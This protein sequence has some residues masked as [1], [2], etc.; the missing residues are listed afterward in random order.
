MKI[1]PIKK[2]DNDKLI[3]AASKLASV[4][5]LAVTE[6]NLVYLNIDD[7]YIHQLFPLLEGKKIEKPDYFG[8][9]LIGAHVSTIYPEENKLI[10]NEDLGEKHRFKVKGAYTAKLDTKKY[11]VITVDSPSLVQLRKKYELPQ[12]LCFKNYLIEFHITIGIKILF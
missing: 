4:G 1:L 3:S 8:E 5:Y 9:N 6:H 2:L 10:M 12:L 7:E 11:Y